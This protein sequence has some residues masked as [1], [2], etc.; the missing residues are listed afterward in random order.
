MKKLLSFILIIMVA[1]GS[2]T[3]GYAADTDYLDIIFARENGSI[4]LEPIAADNGVLTFSGTY[5]HGAGYS[6]T[7]KIIDD[8]TEQIYALAEKTTRNKGVFKIV[9]GL[10]AASYGRNLT[11]YL[12]GGKDS[13]AY[14]VSFNYGSLATDAEHITV[15]S[16][17]NTDTVSLGGVQE[18]NMQIVVSGTYSKGA[19]YKISFELSDTVKGTQYISKTANS[20][21][22]GAFSFDAELPLEAYGRKLTARI[23]SNKDTD[24]AELIFTCSGGP[25]K[26][27]LMV[28]EYISDIE[29]LIAECEA[30]GLSVEYEKTN[31]AV[32]K[33]F[34]GFIDDFYSNGN[35]TEY[36][37]NIKV[38]LELGE[39]TVSDLNG[40]LDG[41]KAEKVAPIYKS[42]K[43]TTDGQSFIGTTDVK[44]EE[45][46]QPIFLNGYGHWADALG[47][48]DS[49]ASLGINTSQYE[50]GPSSILK[51]S[52]SSYA[53]NA[54]GVQ[55]V[56]DVFAK[57]EE[58]N[59]SVTFMTAVHYFP[60]FLYT[61]YPSI[62]TD[63][64]RG[65]T[66]VPYNPTHPE[67]KNALEVFLRAVVPEIKDYK[68]FHSIC[69]ANEPMFV[70]IDHPDRYYEPA[71]RDFLKKKYGNVEA[72]NRAHNSEWKSFDEV[73]FTV[74]DPRINTA[75][76][77]DYRE[78]ND[79]ILTEWFAWMKEI[80]NDIDPTI[81]VHVKC[82]AYISSGG[83]GARRRFCGTNYEKWSQIMDLNGCDA[84]SSY[85]KV[86]SQLQGKM[87][88]YDFMTSMKNAPI[89]NSE[90]HFLDERN[91]Y[92]TN[93]TKIFYNENEYLM[94][95]ADVWQGAV[96]GRASAVY[97]LWD[98]SSRTQSG[99]WYYNCNLSKRADYIAGI[100]RINHDLNRLANEVTAIQ[101]KGT[102]VG[103][104]YSN[105][106]QISEPYFSAAMYEAYRRMINSGEKVFVANDTYPEKINENE[107]LQLLILPVCQN[108][109]EKVW[110]ELKKFLE[111]GGKL[112]FAECGNEY[113]DEKGGSLTSSLKNTVLS[114]ST[115]V[116]FSGWE[117]GYKMTGCD[118]VYAAI[119][120]ALS[121]LE[122]SVT[123]AEASKNTEWTA[124]EY[125]GGYVVNLFNTSESDVNVSLKLTDGREFEAFDLTEN[126]ALKGDTLTLT[127]Y[128]TKLVKLT[129]ITEVHR[130]T[131][132][133][134]TEI[135]ALKEGDSFAEIKTT[136]S[137]KASYTHVVALYNG[138]G[139]VK[140]E[141][142]SGT[143]DNS[144]K[145][146]SKVKINLDKN[147]VS[148]S[149]I[150]SF[151]FD[152]L[153]NIKPYIPSAV[154]GNQQ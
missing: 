80:I 121:G 31:L 118:A 123:V 81:P 54:S 65:N 41:T 120:D 40:Y 92:A 13:E 24:W 149:V 9:A 104:M 106:S 55:K 56:K 100:G 144:G 35:K 137:P 89:V 37:H 58:N 71:Y 38:V 68:S 60:E 11:A 14:K 42:S 122:H 109:P 16:V 150:K 96:H 4:T 97:W 29:A 136:I 10:S 112:I 128:E 2:L 91:D 139:L 15:Y 134:G 75:E 94:G 34:D 141:N 153:E 132:G 108:M 86:S 154:L 25:S 146:D 102:R 101:K 21:N 111:R 8:E 127:T 33:R 70:A 107:D 20:K 115:R 46:T 88:W 22:G 64:L 36:E 85:G 93:D 7:L 82:S 17:T 119:D 49:F 98:K 110:E 84:W 50:V 12:M 142:V 133:S 30:K 63:S 5:S 152:S 78:F 47:D 105:Y 66:M 53:V 57:A 95:M 90:D 113:Y 125:D 45:R 124:V 6:M 117:S 83:D 62:A 67:V 1:S 76:Y 74:K 73:I 59:L 99:T 23:K 114:N 26:N 130:F 79:D 77:I 18:S 147:A 39:Q 148:G 28:T 27:K 44:G 129:P 61:M 126:E 87:M 140:S 116:S 19:G 69:L 135:T 151:L 103:V 32:I 138:N 72:L 145:I 131:D 43:I 48:Y 143:A 51:Q 3:V 52:G